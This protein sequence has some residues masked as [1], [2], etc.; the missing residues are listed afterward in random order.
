MPESAAVVALGE[1][2]RKA[3]LL[4][5]RRRLDLQAVLAA[6]A[7]LRKQVRIYVTHRRYDGGD[8]A[9]GGDGAA[10]AEGGAVDAEQKQE[11][12]EQQQ[13]QQSKQRRQPA[14]RDPP[15]WSLHVSGRV[16][17]DVP[18]DH[19]MT[20][21][22]AA[23]QSGG[24]GAMQA[25]AAAAAQ[26]GAAGHAFTSL[27]RRV[28]ITLHYK[29]QKQQQ[30]QQEEGK[31][32]Q[33]KQQLKQE[34]G[35]PKPSPRLSRRRSAQLEQQQQAKGQQQQQQQQQAMEEDVKQ[36]QQQQQQEGEE[37]DE[38]GE[39]EEEEEVIVWEKARHRGPHRDELQVMRAGAAPARVTVRLEPDTTPPRFALPP[40][41]AALLKTPYET[42]AHA[43]RALLRHMRDAGMVSLADPK[44]LTPSPDVA[45]ALGLEPG[46]ELERAKLIEVVAGLLEPMAPYALTHEVE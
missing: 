29:R 37:E 45:A 44:I 30:Q 5:K 22:L 43:A 36:E 33:P 9:G 34:E 41:L 32:A 17:P 19:V 1:L 35:A 21:A 10:E 46:A 39:Q 13:Q 24:P 16:D 23:L 7:P 18:A 8:G 11:G 20:A 12:E 26:R 42:R 31:E 27:W 28:T 40:P 14:P 6:E 38:E 15:R 3:D 2:E 4:L 25:A